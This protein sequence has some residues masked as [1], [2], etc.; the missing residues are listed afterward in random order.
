LSCDWNKFNEFVITTSDTNGVINVWD[1]RSPLNPLITLLGHTRA[2]KTVKFSPF[3]ESVI[4][5]VSYDMTTR[6]WDTNAVNHNL[7]NSSLMF[8][9][10]QHREFVYGF[11]FNS[12]VIDQM[13]DCSWDQ[14][15]HIFSY[16]PNYIQL[17][18]L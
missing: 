17:N 14:F 5:S 9:S 18:H 16:S 15:V 11:D 13:A 2:V 12:N 3:R 7:A 10:Q 1:I 6:L 4:G 8:T